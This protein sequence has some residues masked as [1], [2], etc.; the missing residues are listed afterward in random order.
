MLAELAVATVGLKAGQIWARNPYSGQDQIP[1]ASPLRLCKKPRVIIGRYTKMDPDSFA[2]H[3][4]HHA[5]NPASPGK[6][7]VA[8][9]IARDDMVADLDRGDA[10]PDALYNTGG[11]VAEDAR[12]EPLWVQPADQRRTERD[13]N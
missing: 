12:E 13:C 11:L 8:Y 9:L 4:A 5:D 6:Q 10:G 2:S 7:T 1:K 3:P